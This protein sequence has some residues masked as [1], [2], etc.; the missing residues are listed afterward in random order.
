MGIYCFWLPSVPPCF[1]E[2]LPPIASDLIATNLGTA[3]P[4]QQVGE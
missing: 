1:G 3:F 2:F 4:S